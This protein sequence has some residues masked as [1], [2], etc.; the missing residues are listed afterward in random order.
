MSQ[1]RFWGEL[2]DNI[3]SSPFIKHNFLFFTGSLFVSVLNYLYYPVLGRMLSPVRFGEVQTLLTLFLQASIFLSILTFVTV[4]VTVNTPV[5]SERNEILLGLEKIAL[6]VG[7][8]LL[9]IAL[10]ITPVLKSF[11]HF[12]ETSSFVALILALAFSIPLSFRMAFL[13][14]RKAFVRA[15]ITDGSGSLAKLILSPMLV[16]AGLQTFGAIMGL[17]LSQLVSLIPGARWSHAH[18]FRGFGLA[19]KIASLKKLKPQLVF[20]LVYLLAS[21][22]VVAML[23][24][25]IIAIKHYFSPEEAGFYAGMATVARIVY[26][27]TAPFTA[28]LLTSVSMQQSE[29]KNRLQ[30]RGSVGLILGLGGIAV[31]AMSLYPQLIIKI[32]VGSKYLLYAGYLPWLALVMILLA[33]SNAILMYRIALRQY[34]FII[35]PILVFLLTLIALSMRHTSIS[36]VIYVVLSGSAVMVLALVG[37]GFAQKMIPTEGHG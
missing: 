1:K 15:S 35:P 31:L 8:F 2:V 7:Y 30:V 32:L 13:R 3:L 23:S 37:Q 9:G 27:L 20:T 26:F 33:V 21:S 34:S 10:I 18:G 16:L 19:T 12:T 4:H 28:V 6:L 17:A 14:G 29:S 25:D 5:E 24:I 22:A 36:G 11:L